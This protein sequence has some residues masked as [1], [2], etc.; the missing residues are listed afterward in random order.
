MK[1]K[2]IIMLAAALCTA[3]F[4]STAMAVTDEASLR[5]AVQSDGTVTLENNIALTAAEGP[6]VIKGTTTLV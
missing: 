5:T 1:K 4:A 3:L 2:G 6:L